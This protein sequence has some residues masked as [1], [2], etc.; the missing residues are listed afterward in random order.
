MISVLAITCVSCLKQTCRSLIRPVG[1][2]ASLCGRGRWPQESVR[3]TIVLSLRPKEFFFNM[4]ATR[5][6]LIWRN[7][8]SEEC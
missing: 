2:R 8:D 3:C 5:N 7:S 6:N 1:V 4:G